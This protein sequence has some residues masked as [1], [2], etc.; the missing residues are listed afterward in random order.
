MIFVG[1]IICIVGIQVIKKATTWFDQ[2]SLDTGR[3]EERATTLSSLWFVVPS[4]CDLISTTLL[5][6]GLIY[7]TPSVYQMVRSSIVGFSALFSF[8]FLARR[9][10][11]H[12]WFSALIIL[13]GISVVAFNPLLETLHSDQGSDGSWF[14]PTLLLVSQ[15]FVALQFIL[16]EYLMD[17]FQLDPVRAMGIEGFFGALLLVA[18]LVLAS[19]IPGLPSYLD[20]HAGFSQWFDSYDLIQSSVVLAAMVSVFNFFGL[21]VSTSIGIPGRS[22]LD[23]LRTTLIWL[24]AIHYGYDAFSWIQLLGFLVLVFGIF[25][26]NGVFSSLYTSFR[27]R[28]GTRQVDTERTPLLSS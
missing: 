15:V 24:V 9:F 3:A 18:G 11:C 1:E 20:I 22:V 12:E 19:L 8:V 16:E 6:L 26:F 17:R 25:I 10:L 28:F 7:T 23:A 13:I 27:E 21:A 14:G 2:T 5:N 4:A